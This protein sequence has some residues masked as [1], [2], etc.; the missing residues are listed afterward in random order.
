[1]IAAMAFA[2]QELVGMR[3]SDLP[4]SDYPYFELPLHWPGQLKLALK[5]YQPKFESYVVTIVEV[6]NPSDSSNDRILAALDLRGVLKKNEV[7]AFECQDAPSP[8][9]PSVT[10]GIITQK[11]NSGPKYGARR[12]WRIDAKT[13][14]FSE[15]PPG[16]VV[17]EIK[18]YASEE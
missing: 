12:A 10:I 9:E 4:K 16:K 3:W 2:D 7:A 18:S 11:G 14:K 15:I 6:T 13:M 1:M 8:T 5:Y 17:C